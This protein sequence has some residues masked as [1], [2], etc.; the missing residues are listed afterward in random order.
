MS[1]LLQC[2]R[3]DDRHLGQGR[4][5]H[6][7]QP[8]PTAETARAFQSPTVSGHLTALNRQPR[9]TFPLN[10]DTALPPTVVPTVE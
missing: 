4:G 1:G 5:G 3:I 8:G 7:D 6:H 2:P 9:V 10:R